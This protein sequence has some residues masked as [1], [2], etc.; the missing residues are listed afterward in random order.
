MLTGTVTDV[1][2]RGRGYDHVVVCGTQTLSAVHS[3]H[4]YPRGTQVPVALD[5]D[6]C[7]A[8]AH[9]EVGGS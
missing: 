8:F 3:T 2:Y 1:A 5:A 6:G 9:G 7:L 4:P